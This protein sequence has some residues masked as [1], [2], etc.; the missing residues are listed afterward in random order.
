MR[1]KVHKMFWTNIVTLVCIKVKQMYTSKES[2]INSK[3]NKNQTDGLRPKINILNSQTRKAINKIMTA[4]GPLSSSLCKV[5][6]LFPEWSSHYEDTAAYGKSINVS[7]LILFL[8]PIALS[9]LTCFLMLF[10]QKC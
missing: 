9:F 4:L 10:P 1:H 2:R 7:K 3:N 5:N 8:M 6:M